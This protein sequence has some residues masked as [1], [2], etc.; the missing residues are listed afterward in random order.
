MSFNYPWIMKLIFTLPGVLTI[1]T[2]CSCV[3]FNDTYGKESGLFFTPDW[4]D[5][6]EPGLGCILYIFQAKFD[7]IV[8]VTFTSFDI[9]SPYF[10]STNSISSISYKECYSSDYIQ[11]YTN[12]SSNFLQEQKDFHPDDGFDHPNMSLILCGKI[13]PSQ[14]KIHHSYGPLLIIQFVSN[15]IRA[16]SSRGFSGTYRF[17][18]QSLFSSDGEINSISCDYQFL[19]ILST[20]SS[21][22]SYGRF[23]SPSFP[24]KYPAD[25][26]CVYHFMGKY[27]ERVKIVFEKIV[28]GNLDASCLDSSDIISVYDGP[29]RSSKLIA[30]LCNDEKFIE[31]TA[32]G[33]DLHLVFR[34]GSRPSLFSQ[35]FNGYFNFIQDNL[36]VSHG[37][38]PLITRFFHQSST[39]NRQEQLQA[40]NFSTI[41]EDLI[42]RSNSR[43]RE[44]TQEDGSCDEYFFGS[45]RKNGSFSSPNY[46]D[47]YQRGLR[48]RFFFYAF[49]GDRVQIVFQDFDLAWGGHK[50]PSLSCEN[51]DIL[52]IFLYINGNWEILNSSCANHMPDKILSSGPFLMLELKSG[53]WPRRGSRGF[54]ATF[55]FITD[56]GMN[57]GLHDTSKGVCSITFN[58]NIS[59]NGFFTSPNYPGLYPRNTECNYFF[60]ADEKQQVHINFTHFD[61]R[62]ISPCHPGSSSDYIQYSSEPLISS[63]VVKICGHKRPKSIV[64]SGNFLRILF[65][66]NDK[67]DGSG[68]RAQYH[69]QVIKSDESSPNKLSSLANRSPG[70]VLWKILIFSIIFIRIKQNFFS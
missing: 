62:G 36:F 2:D 32:S 27:N 34:S 3:F 37:N 56:F 42:K 65:K 59:K 29:S 10:A 61:V 41:D 58:S 46:P 5:S 33:P 48:C 31:I 50:A 67:Y 68:F 64:S 63:R 18:N 11:I 44:N 51:S 52:T 26:E 8:Q 17:L 23:F 35:G 70:L 45:N 13:L 25:S 20:S 39:S 66:T 15:S 38:K 57:F 7:Q 9:Y 19:S 55:Q 40:A 12:P 16:K 24:A 60:H 30:Q 1:S 22:L 49:G 54:Q 53:F 14:L 21:S 28:L 4:P 47:S 43:I 6:Y 69:F